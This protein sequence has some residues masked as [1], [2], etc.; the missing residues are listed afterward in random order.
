MRWNSGGGLAST[1]FSLD[2]MASKHHPRMECL[3]VYLMHDQPTTCP[4]CGGRTE[5]VGEEPQHHSCA[6]GFQFL[7]FEDQD[8]GLVEE[9]SGWIKDSDLP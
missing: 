5:W 9:E 1:L 3:P 8:F 6:C 4:N 7:I 2:A